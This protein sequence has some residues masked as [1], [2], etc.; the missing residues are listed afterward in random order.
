MREALV[1]DYPIPDDTRRVAH[2]A[3]PN[4]TLYLHLRD[5]FG[6]LVD[7]Q[8]FAHLF[9]HAGTPALAPARLAL[10]LILQQ[11]VEKVGTGVNRDVR[12]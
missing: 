9:A 2:A 4:G 8:H 6:M 12:K 11:L 3:V 7:N 5:R 10:V 1:S